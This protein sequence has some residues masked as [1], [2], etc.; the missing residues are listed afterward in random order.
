MK[1][2]TENIQINMDS[3]VIN[4]KITSDIANFKI[5]SDFLSNAMVYYYQTKYSTKSYTTKEYDEFKKKSDQLIN[6]ITTL[7]E[8]FNNEIAVKNN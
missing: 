8:D 1:N 3:L 7:L 4:T 5:L 2:N 6:I